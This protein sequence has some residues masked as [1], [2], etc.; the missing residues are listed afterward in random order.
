MLLC[1]AMPNLSQNSRTLRY[2]WR[3]KAG[4]EYNTESN[5]LDFD[6]SKNVVF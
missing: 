3:D 2:L 6:T 5:S 4:A 1:G